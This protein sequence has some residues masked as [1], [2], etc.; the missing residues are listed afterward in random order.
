VQDVLGSF[1]VRL[2]DGEDL[3]DNPEHG[4]EGRLDRVAAV[5]TKITGAPRRATRTRS[6]PACRRSAIAASSRITWSRILMAVSILHAGDEAS[7]D[8]SGW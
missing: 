8:L 3:V 4:I 7:V 6:L 2:L 5:A 1:R